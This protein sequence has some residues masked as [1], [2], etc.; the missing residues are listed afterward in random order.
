MRGERAMNGGTA[1]C[2][3]PFRRDTTAP[4]SGHPPR[5]R[6]SFSLPV[7]HGNDSCRSFAPTIERRG[8]RFECEEVMDDTRRP[9]REL[10][11]GASP[12]ESDL[13]DLARINIR[14]LS[15]K[16]D[17]RRDSVDRV[18]PDVVKINLSGRVVAV[19][20]HLEVE[21]SSM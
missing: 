20:R 7:R 11:P 15:D 2:V 17:P 3:A 13:D 9:P 19:A 14:E 18:D 16:V 6:F 10:D 1:S 4:N 12:L 5:G 8:T 21:V